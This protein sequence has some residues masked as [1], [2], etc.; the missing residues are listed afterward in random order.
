MSFL[1]PK[2]FHD[3]WKP[4]YF[5]GGGVDTQGTLS[6]GTQ[7]RCA[8]RCW[9]AARFSRGGGFVFNSIH[10]V[11][12]NTPIENLVAIIDAVKEFNGRPSSSQF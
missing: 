3:P 4:H 5:W 8:H 11:Q 9:S 7:R 1:G 6:F 10:N 12:A 2:P